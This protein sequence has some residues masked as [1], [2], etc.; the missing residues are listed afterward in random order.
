[1]P[2]VNTTGQPNPSDYNLG[3]GAVYFA[4]LDT[5]TG[6]P[7]SYRHLGNCPA[8]TVTVEPELLEHQSSRAGLKV[9]DLEIVVS[10]KTSISVTL[11]EATNFENLA[12]FF[13]GSSV[14]DETNTARTTVTNVE[15]SS[16]IV[17]GRWYD[18]RNASGARLYD[19]SPV[20]TPVADL[21]VKAGAT[22]PG[23]TITLG[24]D[25]TVDYVMGRIF[26]PST[27]TVTAGHKLFFD[28]STA[29]NEVAVD[30]VYGLTASQIK[31][32]LKF[33]STNPADAGKRVEYQFH[34][35][36][37]RPE[38]DLALIGDE[39][40]QITLTGTANKNTKLPATSQVVTITTHADS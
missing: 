37:I 11:D 19:I 3:R 17:K 4:S 5:T 34:E 32:A 38:G 24:T 13:S 7:L 6:L 27:S 40:T 23:S 35:V 30:R 12:F 15:I 26:I 22:S 39:F 14:N 31:G 9:T 29:N 16:S 33:V 36:S 10:Q 2:G 25:Y 20:V 18:L 8:F 1:M 21:V 28:Y